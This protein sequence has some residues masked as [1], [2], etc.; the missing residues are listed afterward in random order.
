M[1]K[2]YNLLFI[3]I[4]ASCLIPAVSAESS[5][6]KIASISA[7]NGNSLILSDDGGVW[8]WGFWGGDLSPGG[9]IEQYRVPVQMPGIDHV[10]SVC[11]G[12]DFGL[13]LKD[14]GT[15]WAWGFNNYGQLGIGTTDKTKHT[16]PVQVH[17]DHVIAISIGSCNAYALKDD[18][19]V[20]AWGLNSAGQLGDGTTINRPFPVQVQGLDDVKSVSAGSYHTLALKND[21]TVWAW[22]NNDNGQ[23][24]D[25]TYISS[26]TPQK[27]PVDDAV[28]LSAGNYQNIILK[29]DGTVW[30]WGPNA[31]IQPRYSTDPVSQPEIILT[32]RQV[33]G[34]DGVVSVAT[35]KQYLYYLVLKEDGTVWSWGKNN[36]G[37][38]GDGT[39]KDNPNPEKIL[40]GIVDISAG[41]Y[42]NLALKNDGSL[43]AWGLNNQGQLGDGTINDNE[44][45]GRAIP[46]K[47]NINTAPTSIRLPIVSPLLGSSAY[48]TILPTKGVST[49]TPFAN[50]QKTANDSGNNT[51]LSSPGFDVSSLILSIGILIVLYGLYQLG[52]RNK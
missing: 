28:T 9:K 44:P 39:Y 36:W 50:I 26:L 52:V 34:L 6:I 30:I 31:F 5:V 42:H 1:N 3:I 8:A 15:V 18:G 4:I 20:W 43:W 24:G 16:P 40:D 45:L 27:V 32:P 49:F 11:A 22:G 10:K 48:P 25:G 19:T 46:V 21:G 41:A 33:T 23:L 38:L 29:N 12:G 37:E 14:D 51:Q 7:G 47:V 13:V 2:V 17:I 35:G